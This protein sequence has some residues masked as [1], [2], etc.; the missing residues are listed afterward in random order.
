MTLR[1]SLLA[2]CM[3]AVPSVALFSHRVPADVRAGTRD[4]VAKAMAWCRDA[5]LQRRAGPTVSM[6]AAT[7][8]PA[9]ATPAAVPLRPEDAADRPEAVL[10]RLG[11]M[12]LECRPLPGPSG[13]H[14]ASCAVPLDADGQLLR[15]F[16]G[17][18]GDRDAAL[19]AL[20][21]EVDGWRNRFAGAP[22]R[23]LPVSPV[24]HP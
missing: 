1:T 22:R 2:V 24:A 19:A 21:T 8:A 16:H 14:V 17:T 6:A 5:V 9:P 4:A 23:E 3:V 18:G 10:A 13:G 12:S 15:V 7:A 20:A 11:A